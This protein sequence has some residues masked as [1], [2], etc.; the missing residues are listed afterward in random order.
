[1]EGDPGMNISA[2]HWVTLGIPGIA[3]VVAALAC[4][5]Y[6]RVAHGGGFSRAA[7]ARALGVVTIWVVL[8]GSTASMGVFLRTD[9]RPPPFMIMFLTLIGVGLGLGFGPIGRRLTHLSFAA[10]VG[11]H[12]FRFPLELVMHQA[13]A[14]GVMPVHMSFEGLNFDVLTGL[15]A[16]P[17]A[18]L[19]A[20]G[21]APRVL[22]I[23]WNALGT[24]LLLAIM[25]I[26]M[27]SS[28][29]LRLFGSEPHQ[30]NTWVGHFPFVYLPTVL[31]LAALVGHVT[32]WRK[33]FGR[34]ARAA[35]P[36]RGDAL[37]RPDENG[38]T[39]QTVP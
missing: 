10:L 26:A 37:G 2:S 13:A 7:F 4:F 12:A 11:L 24:T 35:P 30:V 20:S 19:A 21:R 32:L 27:V 39:T 23:A 22:L 28:P 5:G 36:R 9:L 14:E 38:L 34:E 25:T 3:A 31:V 17:V 8:I 18:I 33:L 1:V 16:I 15:S 6:A 29:I